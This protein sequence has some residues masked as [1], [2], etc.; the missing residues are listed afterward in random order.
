MERAE[1]RS[2][3]L[4]P[5]AA[6]LICGAVGCWGGAIVSCASASGAE[7][8]PTPMVPRAEYHTGSALEASPVLAS[9]ERER[10]LDHRVGFGAAAQG[11]A[12]GPDCHVTSL[13]DRGPG[14]LRDC[15]TRDEP[16]WVV[17]DVSGD[18]VLSE[19][20]DVTSFTTIDGRDAHIRI[21]GRGLRLHDVQHVIIENVIFF[22]GQ[23]DAI[24]LRGGRARDVWID[25]CTLSNFSDGLIDIVWGAT[26][27]TVSW[28]HFKRHN[29]VMLIGAANYPDDPARRDADRKIRVTLHHNWF[30]GTTQRHPRARFAWVHAFNNYYQGWRLY[31]VA[32]SNGSQC[33]LERNVFEPG[34]NTRAGL[35]KASGDPK[36]GALLGVENRLLNGAALDQQGSVFSAREHYEHVAAPPNSTLVTAI[37]R[38][39]GWK[40]LPD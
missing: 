10:L 9:P 3:W 19:R 37:R 35:I 7:P 18:I 6:L 23:G 31:A 32:C 13:A 39:A 1:R 33:L 16:T 26:N 25:H 2:A 36:G 15:A 24:E 29:K 20:I 38:R 21:R 27:V 11:G 22:Q 34:S 28:S 12:G 14:T 30:E 40:A 17:F 8:P 4:S 5:F